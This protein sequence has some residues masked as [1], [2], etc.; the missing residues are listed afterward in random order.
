LAQPS[1]KILIFDVSET[2]PAGLLPLYR[3]RLACDVASS[4]AAMTPLS[5][6]ERIDMAT[7][8]LRIALTLLVFSPFACAQ[9]APICDVT[10]RPDPSSPSYAATFTARSALQN[11]RGERQVTSLRAAGSPRKAPTIAGSQSAF[12]A[13]PILNLPGRNGLDLDLTLYYSSVVWTVAGSNVTFNADQDSPSYG[14]R[15]GFGFLEKSGSAYI[16]T[17]PDGSKHLLGSGQFNEDT[18][19]SERQ[20]QMVHRPKNRIYL[21]RGT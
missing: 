6:K 3:E 19:H 7:L 16:W 12:Y 8:H 13:I 4:R 21:Q 15:L 2:S 10:C 11:A 17:E 14:F 1:E 9:P 5:L 20:R 18:S